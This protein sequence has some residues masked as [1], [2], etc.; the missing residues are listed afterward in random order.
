MAHLQFS[1]AS[2]W[3]SMPLHRLAWRHYAMLQ[4]RGTLR[5][6]HEHL[7]SFSKSEWLLHY[8]GFRRPQDQCT[9]IKALHS[10]AFQP[11][12]LYSSL[13]TCKQGISVAIGNERC[14]ESRHPSAY[15]L[16]LGK[17]LDAD[18]QMLS[19]CTLSRKFFHYLLLSRLI[20]GIAQSVGYL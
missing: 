6:H 2:P 19:E 8:S 5:Y 11:C 18:R 7:I 17:M 20:K 13:G 16:L 14:E 3:P 4:Q 1:L 10:P 9:C 15:Q 12:S